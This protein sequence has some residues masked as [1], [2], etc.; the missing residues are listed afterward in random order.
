VPLWRS[1]NLRL[2]L[3]LSAILLFHRLL[4]RFFTRL[5]AHLLTSDA[6]P[7]RKR[8][9]RTS[10]TLTS[11]FAPA[12]GASLAGFMLGVC[13]SDQ[14]RITIAIYVL[15]RA[16]EVTYNLAEDQGWI[17]GKKGSKFERPWWWGSWM[18]MPLAG[19]QLLHAFVFDRDCFPKARFPKL[20]LIGI[21]ALTLL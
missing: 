7:F 1:P 14:L 12:V 8:N 15:S 21:V 10:R 11:K 4:F 6:Q 9:P 2:S 13:P 19:G 17:W 3:S 20:H 5:R 18:L 16:A